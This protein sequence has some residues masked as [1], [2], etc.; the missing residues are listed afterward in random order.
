MKEAQIMQIVMPQMGMTMVEGTIERWLKNDGDVVE[1]G[2]V[3]AEFFTEKMTGT[4]EAPESGVL[5]ILAEEGD[6]V[7][8]GDVIAEIN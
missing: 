4:I 6:A 1:K 5:K 8:C 7:P 2:D 3:I